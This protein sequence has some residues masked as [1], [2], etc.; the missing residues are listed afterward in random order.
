MSLKNIFNQNS[1]YNL[2]GTADWNNIVAGGGG[3]G[4]TLIEGENIII[5]EG[6]GEYTIA[7]TLN[8]TFTNTTTTDLTISNIT[9]PVP[10]SG[11]DGK[12]LSYNSGTSQMEWINEGAS[13]VQSVSAGSGIIVGGSIENPIIDLNPA[14]SVNSVVTTDLAIGGNTFPTPTG[15]GQALIYNGTNLIFASLSQAESISAGSNINVVVTG[16]DAEV[17]VVDAPTFTGNVDCTQN[18][19]VGGIISC[20]D[21]IIGTVGF[22]VPASTDG[23]KVLT[24]DN[25]NNKMYWQEITG[26]GSVN[27]VTAGTNINVS[28]TLSNPVVNLSDNITLTSSGTFST[29]RITIQSTPNNTNGIGLPWLTDGSYPPSGYV[30]ASDGN[31][32]T[33]F[34]ENVASGQVN[35]VTAGD[36]IIVSGTATNPIVGINP[37]LQA[38]SISV[39]TATIQTLTGGNVNVANVTTDNLTLTTIP[40]NI[41]QAGDD[42]KFLSYNNTT[43]EME[44]VNGGGSGGGVQSVTAGDSI[45]IT[46][47][48]TNPIIGVNPTLQADSISVNTC[49]IGTTLTGGTLNVGSVNT[50]NLSID[51]VTFPNPNTAVEGTYLGIVSGEMTWTVYPASAQIIAGSGI[52]VTNVPESQ[53]EI[54]LDQ[55]INV[56]SVA[57]TTFELNSIPLNVPQSTDDGKILSYNNTTTQMEWITSPSDGVQAVG[58]DSNITIGGNVTYPDVTLNQTI[59]ITTLNT[60]DVNT[61]TFALNTIPLIAPDPLTDGGKILSYNNTTNAMDW[62]PAG[63]G[64]GNVQQVIGTAN[65]VSVD[66]TDPDNPIVGLPSTIILGTSS[67]I[68]SEDTFTKK[69]YITSNDISVPVGES[70]VFGFPWIS[71]APADNTFI[72]ADG[73]TPSSGSSFK[74]ISQLVQ[75]SGDINIYPNVDNTINLHL[76]TTN[77]TTNAVLTSNSDILQ[78]I[79]WTQNLNINGISAD[80]IQI[81]STPSNTSPVTLPTISDGNHPSANNIMVSTGSSMI[82]AP[83][84]TI[85]SNDTGDVIATGN[86][87]SGRAQLQLN[88]T[89]RADTFLLQS[90]GT[91]GLNWTTSNITGYMETVYVTPGTLVAYP[92]VFYTF[93]IKCTITNGVRNIKFMTNNTAE[94]NHMLAPVYCGNNFNLTNLT[95]VQIPYN[96]LEYFSGDDVP[97]SAYGYHNDITYEGGLFLD[98]Q[99]NGPFGCSKYNGSGNI[100]GAGDIFVLL[101]GVNLNIQFTYINSGGVREV[102]ELQANYGYYFCNNAAWSPVTT[103][104]CFTIN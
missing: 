68:C 26:G 14:V 1:P 92:N 37:T 84:S 32:G 57:T 22:D 3:G 16:N 33:N 17:S 12:V 13:G 63:G 96:T 88:A 19:T 36:S 95:Y 6:Q 73:N 91:T 10:V 76:T 40:F 102:L 74:T 50:D 56:T 83:P 98:E 78:G 70:S 51:N 67:N 89:N 28:G 55:N 18:L 9:F 86:D 52:V 54:S 11:D 48:S 60:T 8:P 59:T 100:V 23:N 99:I 87:V 5:T 69:I 41:P 65:E 81:R 34:V 21:V 94:I 79:V 97:F 35:S 43:T 64:G 80:T 61:D 90:V 30:L 49:T 72:C 103:S 101:D 104:I 66:N 53:I 45:L 71:A 31:G 75:N 93:L 39:N 47:T 27:E 7:T 58:G 24:Y 82:F 2:V 15:A 42:G 62:I 85:V 25:T 44:W 46:G 20:A 29:P 38:D 4:V 77:K